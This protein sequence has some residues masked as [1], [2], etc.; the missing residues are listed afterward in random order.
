MELRKAIGVFIQVLI[1][2]VEQLILQL[3]VTVQ[4]GND[5]EVKG[6]D[7]VFQ[8]ILSGDQCAIGSQRRGAHIGQGQQVVVKAAID[9]VVGQR[10]VQ[11]QT[12]GCES[13]GAIRVQVSEAVAI[14]IVF[15]MRDFAVTVGV[16]RRRRTCDVGAVVDQVLGDT[17]PTGVL[18]A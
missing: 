6:G 17:V 1:G 4:I 11:G 9:V 3:P 13:E 12:T 7:F 14:H 10:R 2:L 15:L 8:L 18:G 16:Q 5:V